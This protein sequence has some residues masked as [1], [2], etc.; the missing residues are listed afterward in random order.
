MNG[1][2]TLNRNFQSLT[3]CDNHSVHRFAF[4][5]VVH[6]A[7]EALGLGSFD[8]LAPE[9]DTITLIFIFIGNAQKRNNDDTQFLVFEA[10]AARKTH[11][12]GHRFR[13]VIKGGRK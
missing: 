12:K 4:N 13:T 7:V 8:E 5:A 10:Q 2:N 9:N 1:V 6:H 11:D 3:T